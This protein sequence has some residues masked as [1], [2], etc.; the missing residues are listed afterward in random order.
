MVNWSD[1]AAADRPAFYAWHNREH[2]VGAMELGGFLR[3]RRYIAVDADRSFF[4]CYEVDSLDALVG[5]EYRTKVNN[6]SELTL[7]TN[8]VLRNSVR[9]LAHVK[10]SLGIGVGGFALTL[11]LDAQSGQE[12]ELHRYLAEIA[13]PKTAGTS[14]IVGAHYLCPTCPPALMSRW[15]DVVEQ[16]RCHPGSSCWKQPRLIHSMKCAMPVFQT[17]PWYGTAR[18]SQS[19]AAPIATKS[20][21]RKS[22]AGAIESRYSRQALWNHC[23]SLIPT[24]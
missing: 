12:N 8:K 4:N 19:R 23:S 2:M 5:P 1:V 15:N 21:F 17:T 14:E 3:G 6:P 9:G 11:R 18:W 22:R 13:L 24:S 10:V 16:P 20:P 7:R